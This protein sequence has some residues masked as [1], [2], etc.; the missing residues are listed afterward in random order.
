MAASKSNSLVPVHSFLWLSVLTC[1]LSLSASAATLCVNPGGTSGCFASISAAVSAAGPGDTIQVAPG[2]YKEDVIIGK[3][4]SLVGAGSSNTIIDAMG[5]SN[6]IYVDGIDT[7]MLKDVVV[8]GF[9][10]RNANFEG[11]LVTNAS[12]V[13][14]WGNRILANDKSL[15]A[16]AGTCPGIPAFETLEG[17]DCGEGVHLSG[18]DHSSVANNYIAR[19]GGGILIS[20]DTAAAHDNLISGNIAENNPFDCG[21]TLASHPPAELTGTTTPLGVFHNTISNNDSRRNGLAIEGAGA[22]VGIFDSVPGTANYGNVVVGNRLIGNGLPG[23]AMH[24]HAPGQNLSDNLIVF[25]YVAGNGQDTE[26]AATPG[27]T[28]INVFGVSPANGTVISQ[29]VIHNEAV[30]VAVNTSADVE[31]HLN[32][33]IGHATGV[34]NLNSGMVNATENW[35]GCSKGPGTN[36]CA[37]V[38]GSGVLTTPWLTMPFVP[39]NVQH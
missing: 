7:P 5:L 26:D 10:V 20:D 13:T 8:K 24:S 30:D 3:S 35:W 19:N 14:I 34:D 38:G 22:G 23:V 39:S 32:N 27:P 15:D 16:A 17:F 9:T 33:F 36:G 31:V 12:A 29:N 1:L 21:I 28:G 2:T 6:G 4:L 18:A 25:N 11:V 37:S